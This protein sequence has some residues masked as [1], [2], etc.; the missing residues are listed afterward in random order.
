MNSSVLLFLLLT[1]SVVGLFSVP[2]VFAEEQTVRIPVGAAS[3]S[4]ANDDTCYVPSKITI[5]EGNEVEWINEDSTAH[6][7]TSGTPQDGH[8]GLFDSGIIAPRGEFEFTF[9]GFDVGTYPY[10]CI[11]HPWMVGSV[12][13]VDY[14]VE[15]TDDDVAKYESDDSFDYDDTYERDSYSQTSEKSHEKQT[16]LLENQRMFG[17]YKVTVDWIRELPAVNE[18]NGIEILVSDTTKKNSHGDSMKE[19]KGHGEDKGKHGESSHGDKGKHGESMKDKGGHEDK[20]KHSSGGGCGG[21]DHGE[22]KGMKGHEGGCP[23]FQMV[24]KMIP[25]IE[26]LENGVSQADRSMKITLS[27]GNSELAMPIVADENLPGRYTA[28]FVPTV[29]GKYGVEVHGTIHGSPVNMIIQMDRVF[30]KNQ[31][32]RFP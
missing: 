18:N 20:E 16:T 8:D 24:K 10:Y 17:K 26:L 31:I 23:H 7:V 29:A 30:D 22:D 9:N 6:T 2:S 11:A 25:Q 27:V 12:T 13:V 1:V 32:T 19:M 3:P 15:V 14:P 28:V 21:S 5:N 4:C